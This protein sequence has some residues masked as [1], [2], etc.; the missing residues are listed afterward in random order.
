LFT[1]SKRKWLLT[2]Q[3]EMIKNQVGVLKGAPVDQ[4]TRV[5]GLIAASN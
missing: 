3:V 4:I 1:V 2:P 5:S